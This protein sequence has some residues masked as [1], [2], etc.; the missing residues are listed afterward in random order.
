ML[1]YYMII[2]VLDPSR[3]F[4]M[5]HDPVMVMMICNIILISNPK[6]QNKKIN[7]NENKKEIE[8]N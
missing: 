8:N 4:F 5:S 7:K 2:F 3:S 6:F 1:L